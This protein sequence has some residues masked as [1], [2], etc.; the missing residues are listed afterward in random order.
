MWLSRPARLLPLLLIIIALLAGSSLTYLNWENLSGLRKFVFSGVFLSLGGLTLVG[1]YDLCQRK[2]TLWFNF[3][4]MARMRWV[5][6]ALRPFLRSYIVESETEGKPF[7]HE[8]RSMAYRRAKNVRSV[9]PFGSH[10]EIHEPPYE[11][12]SHSLHP[13]EHGEQQEPRIMIGEGNCEKPYSASVLNISGMSFGALGGAAITALN[14]GA[15]KGNFFQNTGEGGISTYHQQG[16]DL[17]WQLASGYFGA[18]RADGKLDEEKF[19]ERAADDRI[20]MIEIKLSQGAKPGHGGVLP[21]PK[22]TQEIADARGIPIGETCYSPPR[23]P[24]FSTPLELCA[25]IAKLRKLSGGKPV[26]IKLCVGMPSEVFALGKAFLETRIVP[27]FIVVDGAEGGTGAAPPEFLDHI[28]MP[29][30]NGLILMRNMLVG[31]RL[32]MQIKLGVSGKLISGFDMAACFALGADFINCGRGFMFSLG[33]IQSLHCH[34][35]HCPTGIATTKESLQRGLDVTDKSERVYHF[36]K[37]TLS[38]MME[39]VGAAGCAHPKDMAP[40]H[41]MHRVTADV[42]R[43]A[44]KAFTLI[45][46]GRLVDLP[47]AT[48]YAKDWAMARSDK[49]GV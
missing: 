16:G 21:G 19:A 38:A 41:I 8:V 47:A 23:H 45:P 2:H 29:L 28:G 31:T 48:P 11:W 13:L 10:V 26:G 9:E 43:P 34:T 17:C 35:N 30:R 24:E 22:V 27:D 40:H 49:F 7:N 6:E 42:A 18:R 3:P 32:D 37:N 1:I 25:F 36:H 15:H 20:K 5:G 12:L 33:C 14:K 39:V 44:D 4:V 46:H